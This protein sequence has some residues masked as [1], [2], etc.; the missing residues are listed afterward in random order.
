[1]NNTKLNFGNMGAEIPCHHCGKK[2]FETF[3]KLKAN[4]H[5]ACAACGTVIVVGADLINAGVKEVETM[6]MKLSAIIRK[7]LNAD[8]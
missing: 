1:M 7:Q 4:N 5:L 3:L 6:R 2:N 8:A